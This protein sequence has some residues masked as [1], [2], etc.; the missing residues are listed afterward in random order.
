MLWLFY[1][2]LA[3]VSE[4]G[5]GG[6]SFHF[7]MKLDLPKGMTFLG[8]AYLGGA[9]KKDISSSTTNSFVLVDNE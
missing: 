6:V 7:L 8:S 2:D 5:T 1:I 9:L 3:I 4:K